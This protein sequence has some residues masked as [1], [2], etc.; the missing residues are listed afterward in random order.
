MVE[1]II[2]ALFLFALIIADFI[3]VSFM[4]LINR[5]FNHSNI[6]YFSYMKKM[7]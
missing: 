7:L 5:F 6:T 3:G 2:I 1:L 4:Y